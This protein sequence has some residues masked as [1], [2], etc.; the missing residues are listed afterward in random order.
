ME[1]TSVILMISDPY[2]NFALYSGYEEDRK[3]FNPLNNLFIHQVACNKSQIGVEL[4][5]SD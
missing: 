1:R 3:F 2:H 5:V 4:A